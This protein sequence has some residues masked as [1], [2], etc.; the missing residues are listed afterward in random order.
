[1]RS[2]EKKIIAGLILL[3]M[4]FL[5]LTGCGK[6]AGEDNL[7][8][9]NTA[10]SPAKEEKTID[11]TMSESEETG[12]ETGEIEELQSVD[13]NSSF[14]VFLLKVQKLSGRSIRREPIATVTAVVQDI[15]RRMGKR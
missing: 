2:M 4:L 9:T 8:D 11:N 12:I 5:C 14:R 3:P 15:C 7:S 1:M 6:S 10:V 13:K